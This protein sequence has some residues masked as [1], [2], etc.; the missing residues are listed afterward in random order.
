MLYQPFYSIITVNLNNLNGLKETLKSALNQDFNDYEIIVIDGASI[1]GS[2]QYVSALNNPRIRCFS[3]RD[4][5]IYDA[6]NKGLA[7]STGKFTVF[8]NAGDFF[9]DPHVLSKVARIGFLRNNKVI[10]GRAAIILSNGRSVLY[11]PSFIDAANVRHWLK[12]ALPNH[13]SMFFPYEYSRNARYRLDLKISSDSDFK[14]RALN[15]LGYYFIDTK[16]ANFTLGGI[17]SSFQAKNLFMQCK[18]RMMRKDRF[19]SYPGALLCLMKSFIKFII[20][21]LAFGKT[22]VIITYMKISFFWILKTIWQKS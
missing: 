6:M 13:Q 16:I 17:S 11:P 1:D 21:L 18:D 10:F 3:E 2:Q 9:Y 19:G 4:N 8:M 5:G 22:D 12:Y 20:N 15:D 7:H 14:I